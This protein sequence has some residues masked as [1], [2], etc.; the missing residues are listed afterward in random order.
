MKRNPFIAGFLSLLVPGLGQIY[1]GKGNKGGAIIAAA[2]LIGNLNIIIL[3]LI[4]MANPTIPTDVPT[5]VTLWAYWIPRIVHDVMS[6]WSITFWL[7][8][9]VDAISLTRKEP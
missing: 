6:F 4:A 3:P 5:P 9:I 8:A 2:I 7:W 1:T